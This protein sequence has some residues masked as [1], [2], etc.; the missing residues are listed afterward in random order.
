MRKFHRRASSKQGREKMNVP[1]LLRA[2][3]LAIGFA[4]WLLPI[5]TIVAIAAEITWSA[6]TTIDRGAWGRLTPLP[7]GEWL[8][9]ITRFS[10]TE[11]S[12]L[13]LYRATNASGPWL[14]MTELREAGRKLDNGHL[15][16][17]SNGAVLLTGRSL[18]EG[19]SYH[20]PVYRSVDRGQTWQATSQVDTSEVAKGAAGSRG[21]WEPF[22]FQLPDGK[23]SVIYSNEKHTGYSQVLSQKTS[24]DGGRTW[25]SENR[26][27]EEAGGGKLRPG[28]GVVNRLIDGKFLLVYEVVG[29]GRGIVHYKISQD[30]F[31]WPT[32]LGTPIP[33]HEAA[34]YSIVLTDGRIL[35]TSCSNTLSISEDGAKTWHGMEESPWTAGFKYNWPALYEIGSGRLAAIISEGSVKLKTG[36]MV[37]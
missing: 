16:T 6:E 31:S 24:T 9:V 36:S 22:L 37:K 32:G 7:D 15:L 21:L 3:I 20:L 4:V 11:P 25:G 18:I 28:M 29:L 19:Q 2:P 5:V 1:P 13:S 8:S 34:P 23:I 27:V 33:G 14:P 26:I 10:R 35:L 12:R 30:G 17:L